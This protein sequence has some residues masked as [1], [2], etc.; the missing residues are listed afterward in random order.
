M[1]SLYKIVENHRFSDSCMIKATGLEFSRYAS[2]KIS[3]FFMSEIFDGKI[4][5][6]DLLAG[7]GAPLIIINL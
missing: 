4:I 2:R 7:L 3:R 6:A 1:V 5:H